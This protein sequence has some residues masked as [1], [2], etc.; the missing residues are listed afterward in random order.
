MSYSNQTG[1]VLLYQTVDKGEIN[2]E[3]GVTEMT[4]GF[5]TAIYLSL[6]GGNVEDSGQE[7]DE[8]L[9][10]WQNFIETIPARK[11][12]SETQHVLQSLPI[13]S[14]NLKI[15]EAAALKDLAWLSDSAS[16]LE[17][18]ATIPRLNWVDIFIT[19]EADGQ[20]E[21]FKYSANWEAW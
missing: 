13:T 16:N 20:R 18:K 11:L 12:R 19:F 5:Q 17:V 3:L 7:A 2:V 21:Q 4:G 14:G 9:Q 10:Y 1:D 15:V 8:H 6:E